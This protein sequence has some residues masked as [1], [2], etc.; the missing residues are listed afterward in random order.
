MANSAWFL[1][2]IKD[3]PPFLELADDVYRNHCDSIG[4]E[5]SVLKSISGLTRCW[6]GSWGNLQR[7]WDE[8]T[9][10]AEER[11][12]LY[13]L[14]AQRLWPNGV[15]R[16]LAADRP[17]K[18]WTMLSRGLNETPTDG[19]DVI[20]MFTALATS[21]TNIYCANYLDAFHP[22]EKKLKAFAKTPTGRY[23]PLI[24]NMMHYRLAYAALAHALVAKEK[25]PLWR[26]A[27]RRARMLLKDNSP[28]ALAYVPV[29]RA[30]IAHQQ[31]DNET[32]RSL[33]QDAIRA[34][35]KLEFKLYAAAARRQ[36]G[37]LLGGDKG[38]LLIEWADNTMG[39]EDIVNPERVAAMLAPGFF[40]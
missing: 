24:K 27:E 6:L 15:T 2:D 32:A 1:G 13:L 19:D 31:G 23:S 35:E 10:D 37:R 20:V 22:L 11:N 39:E 28:M 29:I 34:F 40:L 33:L 8:W 21:Y 4:W 17:D 12:D 38:Q 36:L 26:L 30:A 18:V 7:E 25:R 9:E 5:L 16:W 3:A 14:T